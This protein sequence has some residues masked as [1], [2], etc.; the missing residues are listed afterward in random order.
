MLYAT[1]SSLL[2]SLFA[3]VFFVRLIHLDYGSW[4]FDDS[5]WGRRF[6]TAFP[7]FLTAA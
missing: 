2:G 4:G 3:G 5:S 6:R 7:N 1:F